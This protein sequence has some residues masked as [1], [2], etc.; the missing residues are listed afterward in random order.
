M[1]LVNLK[2]CLLIAES[3]KV[4]LIKENAEKDGVHKWNS[5][6]GTIENED[7]LSGAVREAKEE[8]NVEVSLVN[9]FGVHVKY[10]GGDSNKYTV[11]F[12]YSAKIVKGEP[13]LT[14]ASEQVG[15][16]EDIVELKWFTKE[17]LNDLKEEDFVSN[18]SFLLTRK[19]LDNVT[20]PLD[21]VT[22]QSF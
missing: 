18:V 19:W 6:K 5:V 21:A 12:L 13:K 22:S 9:S 14:D 17:E 7:I 20:Y 1:A 11:Y 4:L 8:V 3:D 16:S 2:V 10:Y 15:R